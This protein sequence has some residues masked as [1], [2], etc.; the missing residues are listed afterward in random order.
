MFQ[1]DNDPKHTKKK[2]VKSFTGPRMLPDLN[3]TEHLL[4]LGILVCKIDKRNRSDKTD[5]ADY[6]RQNCVTLLSSVIKR[7]VVVKIKRW[8]YKT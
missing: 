1:T 6:P 7:L 8:T 2:K 3:L 5:R 4:V